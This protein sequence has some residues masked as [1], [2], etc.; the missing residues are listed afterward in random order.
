[1]KK[2]VVKMIG[3]NLMK[4]VECSICGIFMKKAISILKT[5]KAIE[6]IIIIFTIKSSTVNECFVFNC[7]EQ[8]NSYII[9]D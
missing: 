3:K 5:Q 2:T 1:M 4:V 9:W 6:L 7:E 8:Q